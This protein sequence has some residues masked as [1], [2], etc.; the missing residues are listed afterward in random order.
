MATRFES[1]LAQLQATEE[2]VSRVGNNQADLVAWLERLG[3]IF[4][5][6]RR[7]PRVPASRTAEWDRPKD[8]SIFAIHAK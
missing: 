8:P 4:D 7:E 2:R 3:E 1:L 6:A 5:L